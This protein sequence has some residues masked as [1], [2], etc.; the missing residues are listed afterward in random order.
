MR[1]HPGSAG[2]EAFRAGP[3]T[4]CGAQRFPRAAATSGAMG[5]LRAGQPL[6]LGCAAL[7]DRMSQPAFRRHPGKIR[8]GQKCPRSL[9]PAFRAGIRQIAIRHRP[10]VGERSASGTEIVVNGHWASPFRSSSC[11]RKARG[12]KPPPAGLRAHLSGDMG[13]STP[14]LICL[15][16][17]AAL[18]ITSNAKMSVGS[19]K[20]A[21]ALGMSTTPEI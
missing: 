16:G 17:P 11:R 6:R 12:D 5:I 10:R 7:V 4:L 13:M 15:I 1:E 19:H 18:G 3:A 21:Q 20:V 9:L 14:L 8:R 2:R